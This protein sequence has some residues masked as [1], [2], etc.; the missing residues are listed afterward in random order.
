MIFSTLL[1]FGTDWRRLAKERLEKEK[2]KRHSLRA[3]LKCIS[4][5]SPVFLDAPET[6]RRSTKRKLAMQSSPWPPTTTWWFGVAQFCL[7]E[8][9]M[10]IFGLT[11]RQVA[12]VAVLCC[13]VCLGSQLSFG[14]C[15]TVIG[16]GGVGASDNITVLMLGPTLTDSTGNPTGN[17]CTSLEAVEAMAAPL[18]YNVEIDDAAAWGAKTATQFATYRAIVLGDA[19][20]PNETAGAVGDSPVTAAKNNINVWGPVITGPVAVVGT[21]PVFHFIH[22][23]G[24][25][26]TT[27]AQ[28]TQNAIALA[29]SLSGKPGA[30]ICLS[31]YYETVTTSTTVDVLAPFGNFTV[32]GNN[33]GTGTNCSSSSTILD[34]SNALVKS[35]NILS[36][37]GLSGWNCS[38][39]EAFD[40]FPSI[41]SAVVRTDGLQLPY[42]VASQTETLSYPAGQ[43]TQKANYKA[44]TATQHSWKA[45]VNANTAFSI[46]VSANETACGNGCPA[47][48]QANDPSDFQCRFKEYFSGDPQLPVPVPYAETG[49]NSTKC[50]FYRVENPPPDSAILSDI[51]FTAGYNEPT[52][53]G[54][55]YCDSLGAATRYIRDPSQ[56]PPDNAALN[57][58]FAIDFTVGG[59]NPV[60]SPP[61]TT[62]SGDKTPT[63]NDY[64]VA[65]RFPTGTAAYLKPKA[66]STYNSGSSV[67]FSVQVKV[68][69]TFVNDAAF[70]PNSMPLSIFQLTS[71]GSLQ[72]LVPTFGNPG[73]SPSFWIFDT[74]TNSFTSNAKIPKT[75][76]PGKYRA[77][78]D[79][80]RDPTAIPSPPPYFKHTCIDFSVK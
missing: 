32:L 1:C 76:S 55:L 66:G 74:I 54:S 77:C 64:V 47:P 45:N 7:E 20:C 14:S 67:P 57:H 28:L 24:S 21:D 9:T 62:I 3:Y 5:L 39:H 75:I 58:S 6:D 52:G 63:F 15:T 56:P 80:D 53:P 10:S 26:P 22:G 35:P 48:L 16:G 51:L 49:T 60:G 65:C 46:N 69:T 50:V 40:N 25:V 2:M 8:G 61:D 12:S 71:S 33:T 79:S 78:V 4:T 36:S 43:S 13:F 19:D 29:A 23:T 70:S 68:G 11:L 31:C 34:A 37:S 27:A 17:L 73:G 59:V 30:Y 42:I 44:N 38:A 18:N 41:L 72:Q